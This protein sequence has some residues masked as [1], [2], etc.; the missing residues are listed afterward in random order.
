[1]QDLRNDKP[2]WISSETITF[3]GV[4]KA[5]Y[6]GEYLAVSHRW[7]E[8]NEPDPQLVQLAA[9]QKY[10]LDH[11][12]ITRVFYDLMCL[13]QGPDRTPRDKA[14]FQT[15]LPNIN[16]L[17]LGCTVL[18]LMDRSYMSRFW[19]QFEAWLSFMAPTTDGL[20]SAPEGEL[21]C[22]IYCLHNTPSG[23]ADALNSEWKGRT[24]CAA[25]EILSG[26]DV[27]V[28]NAS[29]KAVQLP[30]ILAM[31][32]TVRRL[33]LRIQQDQLTQAQTAPLRPTSRGS[34][35]KPTEA[36][37][38]E[39]KRTAVGPAWLVEL[40]AN[41]S[42]LEHGLVLASEWCDEQGLD[43]LK[44]VQEAELVDALVTAM[45]LKPGKASIVTK[46]LRGEGRP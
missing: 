30:K 10:L 20:V 6:R 15:M 46:R 25:L 19:T 4:I 1:L 27:T 41:L 42:G 14:E 40:C 29:D 34:S 5:R 13:P 37:P 44:E 28:T 33:A 35:T 12:R 3:E 38:A 31:D 22:T 7:E 39:V 21:R 45:Q 26:P 2:D 36:K 17:Y 9:L 11:P 16:L 18:I 32:A 23:M 8:R 43:S 24:A